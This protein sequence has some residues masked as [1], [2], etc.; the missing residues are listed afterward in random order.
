VQA[1]RRYRYILTLV[2]T[3]PCMWYVLPMYMCLFAVWVNSWNPLL[4]ARPVDADAGI[5]VHAG[6]Y[7]CTQTQC[8]RKESCMA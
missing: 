3:V 7:A 2:S 4:Y 5:S 8:T 1:I 6:T